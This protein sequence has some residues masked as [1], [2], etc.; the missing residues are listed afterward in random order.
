[1][2]ELGH[3]VKAN[4]MTVYGG[5]GSG[6]GQLEITEELMGIFFDSSENH[7]I[8]CHDWPSRVLLVLEVVVFLL[9]AIETPGGR[10]MGDCA[11]VHRLVDS[12]G[13]HA[14]QGAETM[15][16][17]NQKVETLSQNCCRFAACR[18]H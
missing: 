2:A 3:L 8:F 5:M 6:R 4:Q 14:Y 13:G 17:K 12:V 15:F 11:R 16:M 18:S 9:E 1:M 10:H 7:F